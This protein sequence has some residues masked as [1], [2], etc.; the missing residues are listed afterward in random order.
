MPNRALSWCLARIFSVRVS[1]DQVPGGGA[2]S[3]SAKGILDEYFYHAVIIRHSA[4]HL[5]EYSYVD[6]A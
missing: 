6:L 3:E 4:S 1:N 2:S 5:P